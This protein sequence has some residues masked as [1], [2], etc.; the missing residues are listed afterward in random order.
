MISEIYRRFSGRHRAP[1][2]ASIEATRPLLRILLSGLIAS[3]TV[4]GLWSLRYLLPSQP[5]AIRFENF[6]DRRTA[7]TL[8]ATFASIALLVGPWQFRRPLSHH[9]QH[10]LLGWTYIVAVL[11]GWLASL[12]LSLH[13]HTGAAA[14]A[15]FQALGASWFACTLLG[16]IYARA[17]HFAGHRRWMIRS[18]ALTMSAVTL[19]LYVAGSKI[20]GMPLEQTYP[21]IAWLCWTP[22]V[23]LAEWL[24][25]VTAPPSFHSVVDGGLASASSA[26]HEPPAS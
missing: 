11:F 15:G 17:E 10:R 16:L 25:K 23:L 19:R 20:L 6:I 8:H 12:P 2:I 1:P 21:Y 5:Q 24:I 9:A 22:N 13:A 3:A 7:F 18:Y 26:P 14:S 4:I